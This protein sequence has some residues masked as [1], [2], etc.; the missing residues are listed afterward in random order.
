[1][2][3]NQT[4]MSA[5]I[6]PQ[7][8]SQWSWQTNVVAELGP[9]NTMSARANGWHGVPIEASDAAETGRLRKEGNEE[10]RPMP[11]VPSG[12]LPKGPCTSLQSLTGQGARLRLCASRMTLLALQR[13]RGH[14]VNRP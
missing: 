7:F 8:E 3:A 13:T 5:R 2:R 14:S 12:L 10:W 1:M 6:T 11:P 9:V 4:R